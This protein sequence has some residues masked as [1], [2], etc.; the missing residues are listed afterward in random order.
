MQSISAKG[1][2]SAHISDSESDGREV[3]DK[4]MQGSIL[5]V[6]MSPESLV[7]S[8]K[9]REMFRS[10]VYR[11]HLVALVVDEAHCIDKW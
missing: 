3:A 11:R 1:V 2:D 7:S 4:V 6:F 8:C 5:L 9:W 10:S